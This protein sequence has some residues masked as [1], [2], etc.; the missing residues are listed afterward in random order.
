MREFDLLQDYPK[1]KNAIG[2]NGKEKRLTTPIFT[3]LNVFT[4]KP[5]KQNDVRIFG[6]INR[7]GRL[8]NCQTP[9]FYFV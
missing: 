5:V 9:Y 2:S 4:D 7:I 3:Q 1:L 6:L 8:I